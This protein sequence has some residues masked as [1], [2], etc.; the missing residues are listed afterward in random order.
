MQKAPCATG[1]WGSFIQYKYLCYTDIL[2]LYSTEQLSGSR[3][4]YLDRCSPV[5]GERCDEYPPVTMYAMRLASWFGSGTKTG[6]YRWNV[7]LLFG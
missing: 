3:L 5:P 1:N 4:P 7:L 2:P 6:F